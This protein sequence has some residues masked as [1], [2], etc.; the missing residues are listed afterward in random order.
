MLNSTNRSVSKTLL[1][2]YTLL[3]CSLN[4]S[5]LTAQT[6]AEDEWAPGVYM[7]QALNNVFDKA[8][9]MSALSEY[10]WSEGLCLT[11]GIL[12]V[13]N[14][15]ALEVEL[16]EGEAYTFVGGGDEDVR[17][18]DLFIVDRNE[19]VIASDVEDDD[20]PIPDFVAPYSGKYSV[21]LQLIS[22]NAPT[23][24]VALALLQKKG[25]VLQE[26]NYQRTSQKFFAAGGSVHSVSSGVK[27]HD[28]KNQWCIFGVL[29]AS[30][31]DWTIE[32]MFL[33]AAD[34]YLFASADEAISNV[35]L[36]LMDS[37]NKVV[38]EDQD[39]DAYPILETTT[40][41]NLRYELKVTNV[42]SS[43]RSLILVGIVTE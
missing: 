13:D 9:L 33:D 11:G 35:D 21:R 16:I 23:S 18:L 1:F 29:L 3:F 12:D 4:P 36:E 22:G 20:T 6:N 37:N 14:T 32:N 38:A 17:D 19:E 42:K 10:S 28:A 39:D 2:I 31:R 7:Q 43:E 5:S 24:F 40:V 8:S 26:D 25:F 27:W 34:H 30:K 15:L 41:S